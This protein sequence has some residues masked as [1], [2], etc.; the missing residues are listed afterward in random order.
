LLKNDV[1]GDFHWL[2]LKLTG[3]ESNRSAIGA[4]ATVRYGGKIQAKEVLGQS[5]Y[6][7]VND[8]RLHFGIGTVRVADIEIRWPRGLVEKFSSVNADQI[9]HITEGRGI[10]HCEKCKAT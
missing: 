6:L 7:S 2:K 9:V 5:S 8:R 1:S 10:T 3:T 4:R